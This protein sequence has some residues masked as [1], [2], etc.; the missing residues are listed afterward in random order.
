MSGSWDYNLCEAKVCDEASVRKPYSGN[1]Y[2]RFGEGSGVTPA[3]TLPVGQISSS[4]TGWGEGFAKIFV[5]CED[6]RGSLKEVYS[7]DSRK[8]VNSLLVAAPLR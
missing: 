3:P 5:F 1:L 6:F 2:V 8:R 7:W 4:A